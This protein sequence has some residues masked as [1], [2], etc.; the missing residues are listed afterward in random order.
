MLEEAAGSEARPPELGRRAGHNTVF[1][2]AGSVASRLVGLLAVGYFSRR[3]AAEGLGAYNLT[4][5]LAGVFAVLSDLGISVFLGREVAARPREE[6]ELVRHA[7]L[8]AAASGFTAFALCNAVAMVSGYDADLRRWILIASTVTL[9]AP[10][11]LPM[12]LLQARLRG[13]RVA[14]LMLSNQCLNVAATIF[15]V[16]TGQ[17]IETYVAL[18]AV[19]NVVYGGLTLHAARAWSHYFGG[20]RLDDLRGAARLLARAAPLGGLAVFALISVRLDT[21]ILSVV[22]TERSVGFYSSA[23]KLAELLHFVPTAVAASVMPIVAS[24]YT[25]NPQLVA[26]GLRSAFRYLALLAIPIFLGGVV[27]AEPLM[28]LVY[29]AG[30]QPAAAPYRVLMATE[31]SYFFGGVAAAALIG[32][33]Q[34]RQL[35][36][37][38]L[39]TLP[40]NAIACVLLLPRFDYQGA[41]WIGLVTELVTTGYMTAKVA[42]LLGMNRDLLPLG[43][44]ARAFL[45]AVPMLAAVVLVSRSL[46]GGV[47]TQILAGATTYGLA[48]IAVRGLGADDL[49]VLKRLVRRAA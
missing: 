43:P 19:A 39:L 25:R 30:F 11:F 10:A 22:S 40:A 35:V 17:G 45:A 16:A 20:W 13:G 28:T 7:S 3:F 41:A 27:L 37:I 44:A 32:L 46:G 21:F 5:A 2:V 34:V 49:E 48:L 18:I 4:V 33:R 42:A 23:W 6:R 29:G 47:L 9:L 38:Q 24:Q 14:A 15:V 12:A 8:A 36:N 31:V 26:R 1:V